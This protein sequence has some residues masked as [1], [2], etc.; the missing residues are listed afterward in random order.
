VSAPK[1]R[2]CEHR[3]PYNLIG[4]EEPVYYDTPC[5]DCQDVEKDAQGDGRRIAIAV[6]CVLAI[7]AVVVWR[8]S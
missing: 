1:Y 2:P 3:H 6:V 8:L 4:S 7:V 5:P